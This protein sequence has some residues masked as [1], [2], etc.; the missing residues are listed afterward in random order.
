MDWL[1]AGTVPWRQCCPWVLWIP[2]HLLVDQQAGWASSGS[3]DWGLPVPPP[4][5]GHLG[6]AGLAPVE[7]EAWDWGQLCPGPLWSF[8]A[9][10]APRPV[11][12]QRGGFQAIMLCFLWCLPQA[13]LV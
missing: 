3:D 12:L 10:P 5:P 1:G 11:F 13:G 6:Q 9:P 4:F 8:S 7:G 2:I